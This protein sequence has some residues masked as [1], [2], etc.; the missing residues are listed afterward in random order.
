[1][2]P[3]IDFKNDTIY[4]NEPDIEISETAM[5]VFIAIS[6]GGVIGNLLRLAK[7]RC[8]ISYKQW[9]L[10][11]PREFN[12]D[13]ENNLINECSICLDQFKKHT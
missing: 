8:I 6:C 3:N 4:D 5:L 1:M 7:N 13:D 12:S 2:D 10:L 11:K 9:K